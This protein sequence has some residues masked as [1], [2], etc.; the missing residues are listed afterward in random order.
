[1]KKV[2]VDSWYWHKENLESNSFIQINEIFLSIFSDSHSM[3]FCAATKQPIKPVLNKFLVKAAMLLAPGI[4]LL[5][6]RNSKLSKKLTTHL[7]KYFP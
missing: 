6:V 2:E 1:M 4:L 3:V 7:S 5:M